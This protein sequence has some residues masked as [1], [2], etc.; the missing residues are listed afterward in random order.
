M[1]KEVGKFLMSELSSVHSEAYS[2][3]ADEAAI[4]PYIVMS[5]MATDFNQGHKVVS[6]LNFDIW[7]NKSSDTSDINT[8]KE[9]VIDHFNHMSTTNVR[10]AL[11]LEKNMEFIIPD[12]DPKIRRKRVQFTLVYY[13]NNRL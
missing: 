6:M 2:E 9:A 7:D 1:I 8:L 13:D 12:R 11:Y 4:F 10:Y 3:Q 5:E